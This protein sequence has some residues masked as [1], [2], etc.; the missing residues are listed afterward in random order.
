MYLLNPEMRE[1]LFGLV[2]FTFHYV[3][4]KSHYACQK[5]QHIKL[6]TFHYVSIKSMAKYNITLDWFNL[7]STMYL[8]N[9]RERSK[10]S[11]A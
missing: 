1:F 10:K 8:L 5:L 7:H 9:L 6:F 4:I 11:E 3:S 2:E